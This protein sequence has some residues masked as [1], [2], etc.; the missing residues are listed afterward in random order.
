MPTRETKILRSQQNS[1]W[2]KRAFDVN[3]ITILTTINVKVSNTR[4]CLMKELHIDLVVEDSRAPGD[5]IDCDS[6][7]YMPEEAARSK[8]GS[9][10]NFIVSWLLQRDFRRVIGKGS[11]FFKNP[12]EA[13]L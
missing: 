3:A 4:Y 6:P 11:R 2:V 9:T 5:E 12:S 10:R 1:T 13:N 8:L 7:G